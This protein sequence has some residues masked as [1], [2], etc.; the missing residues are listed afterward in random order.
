MS[1]ARRYLDRRN[2]QGHRQH[3]M[4][5]RGPPPASFVS[6]RP[7]NTLSYQHDKS[8][9]GTGGGIESLP[10]NLQQC[11]RQAISRHHPIL[12]ETTFDEGIDPYPP[13]FFIVARM[14]TL[15]SQAPASLPCLPCAFNQA[16][17]AIS[18]GYPQKTP[19]PSLMSCLEQICQMYDVC[20]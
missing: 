8:G 1:C 12:T 11:A 19:C 18:R 3:N 16:L 4:Q 7:H 5:Q 14:C 15:R 9:H 20:D 2:E 17:L 10:D 6:S 13:A